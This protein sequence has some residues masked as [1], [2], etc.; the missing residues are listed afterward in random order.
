[1]DLPDIIASL[2]RCAGAVLQLPPRYSLIVRGRSS[3]D[4]R[5]GTAL[6]FQRHTEAATANDTITPPRSHSEL[7]VLIRLL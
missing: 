1:M 6:G 4:G 5:L 7:K 2:R 3:L